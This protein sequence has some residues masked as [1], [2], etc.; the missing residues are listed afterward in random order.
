MRTPTSLFVVALALLG[1][2]GGG[3][4][5]GKS[6]LEVAKEYG[7][8]IQVRMDK[9]VAAA[10]AAQAPGLSL[11]APGDS[12]L[13]LDAQNMFVAYAGDLE[14]AKAPGANEIPSKTVPHFLSEFGNLPVIGKVALR[15]T[16]DDSRGYLSEE[17]IKRLLDAKY[18]VVIIV[19]P[20]DYRSP[21]AD[22]ASASYVGG[23]I[24][25][26][27]VG[28]EIETGKP[29]GGFT[30]HAESSK[31]L[32]VTV[33]SDG[34]ARALAPALVDMHRRTAKEIAAAIN[35]RWPGSKVDGID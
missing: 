21:E 32:K 15:T 23:S 9:L 17:T 14:D 11:G 6:R 24:D 5:E 29:I 2:G 26:T 25:G 35:A 33:S 16:S 18:V 12:K 19:K 13:T 27:G 22:S 7:P 31:E 20:G 8:R 10:K 28:V 1:C 3:G 34:Q 4:K 30:F